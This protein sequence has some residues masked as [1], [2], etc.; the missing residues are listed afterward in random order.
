MISAWVNWV[1]L[2]WEPPFT[3]SNAFNGLYLI[4]ARL[5][6]I[7]VQA[8]FIPDNTTNVNMTGLQPN[9]TY[10]FSVQPI[11]KMR[12]LYGYGPEAFTSSTTRM[13]SK[14]SVASYPGFV[15]DLGGKRNNLIHAPVFPGRDKK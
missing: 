13:L 9:K 1:Q 3:Q 8:V 15:A 14:Y 11:V 12:T 2:D 10:N 7:T 4:L 5:G 6:D